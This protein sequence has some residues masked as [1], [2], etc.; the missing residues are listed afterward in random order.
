V[1]ILCY[2][3]RFKLKVR[4]HTDLLTQ[5]PGDLD[6]DVKYAPS[7]P[8]NKPLLDKPLIAKTASLAQALAAL[9]QEDF[10]NLMRQIYASLLTSL[11]GAKIQSQV[12]SDVVNEVNLKGLVEILRNISCR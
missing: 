4:Q 11:H 8:N 12:I 6:T 9:H 7:E 1:T 10:L 5:E 3:I 2:L